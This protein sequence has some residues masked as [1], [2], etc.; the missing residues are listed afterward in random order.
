MNKGFKILIV[1]SLVIFAFFFGATSVYAH[2]GKTDSDGGHTDHDTGEYH[3]H[4]GYPAHDHYDIDGDGDIDC[5]YDF[6]DQT[7][8]NETDSKADV[9]TQTKKSESSNKNVSEEVSTYASVIESTPTHPIAEEMSVIHS[10]EFWT[11]FILGIVCILLAVKVHWKNEEINEWQASYRNKRLEYEKS[12]SEVKETCK[13]KV[14]QNKVFYENKVQNLRSTIKE[15]KSKNESL[16]DDRIDQEERVRMLLKLVN[17]Q[18]PE[19][20][21]EDIGN[22]LED[23]YSGSLK[24]PNN[25]FFLDDSTPVSGSITDIKPYGDLTVYVSRTKAC[26]HKDRYCSGVNTPVH[27]YEIIDRIPPCKKCATGYYSGVPEWYIRLKKVKE[28]HRE[29]K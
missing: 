6:A 22:F 12:V 25:V 14:E 10:W 16:S 11:L 19:S 24:I 9:S 20:M 8:H 23:V 3:Y 7:S 13:S 28:D 18:L 4:H 5:P 27:A 2:P 1:F 21:R 15:L 26:Y 29:T 17:S